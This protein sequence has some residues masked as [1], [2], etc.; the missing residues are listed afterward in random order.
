MKK[1]TP[2]VRVKTCRCVGVRDP[3]AVII[4]L[5]PPKS[6]RRRSTRQFPERPAQGAPGQGAQRLHQTVF[7]DRQ[8]QLNELFAEASDPCKDVREC[9]RNYIGRNATPEPDMRFPPV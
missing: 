1:E 6:E 9:P 5:Q 8:R 2:F 3:K 7:P 4:G